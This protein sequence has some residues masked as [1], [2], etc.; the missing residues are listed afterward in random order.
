[1][2]QS[3]QQFSHAATILGVPDIQK[4]VAFYRDKLGF[5]DIFLWGEPT[6]YAVMSR[7]DAVSVHLTLVTQPAIPRHTALYI[8][9]YDVDS[10]YA[11]LIRKD[12]EI[13]KAPETYP[14]DMREF[15]IQDPFG[16]RL[17]FGTHISRIQANE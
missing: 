6:D 8:F 15:D 5:T 7:E 4:G 16:Y 14:Y 1:M 9:V 17:T 13:P 11:E 3:E 2:P 10:L 12:V